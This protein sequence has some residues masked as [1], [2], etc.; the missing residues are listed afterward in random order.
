[1]KI[2]VYVIDLEIPPAVKRLWIRVGGPLVFLLAFASVVD[3]APPHTF[4]P[5][6]ILHAADLMTDFNNLDTRVSAL[7]AAA[8]VPPGTVVAFAG[9]TIPAGW[10]LCD[11]SAVS[12]TTYAGLFGAIGITNGGGDGVTTFNLPDYRGRFL[13]GVDIDGV[14]GR[15][16]DSG[17]RTAPQAGMASVT[18]GPGNQ[19]NLVGSVE[20]DAFPSHEHALYL[21]TTCSSDD[22]AG[23]VVVVPTLA[24]YNCGAYETHYTGAVSN[25]AGPISTETRPK[26]VSVN[27][28][29][30]Y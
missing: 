2:K 15:D 22:A 17:S 9:P 28:I 23:Y 4:V 18:G 21:W 6:D 19:G 1:V 8:A 29:V 16:N 5:N 27:Y 12:R 10:L 14:P 24:N 26:N 3:A 30:K 13:R 25:A 20:A 7:E 11:G